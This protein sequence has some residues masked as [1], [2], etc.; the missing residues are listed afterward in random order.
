MDMFW[1]DRSE[2]RARQSVRQ[3]L[4]LLRSELGDALE[5][6]RDRIR[7]RTESLW[8]DVQDLGA[9][10]ERHLVNAADIADPAV[11]ASPARPVEPADPADPAVDLAPEALLLLP[12]ADTESLPAFLHWLDTER[13]TV[14]QRIRNWCREELEDATMRKDRPRMARVAHLW[15]NAGPQD[16]APLEAALEV[17]PLLG[18]PG[19][20]LELWTRWS[21]QYTS[22]LGVPPPESLARTAQNL[23]RRLPG[24]GPGSLALFSPDLVERQVIQLRLRAALDAVRQGEG[25]ILALTGPEGI[26]KSRLMRKFLQELSPAGDDAVLTLSTGPLAPEEE[27]PLGAV[28][29]LLRALA[30]A[31]G[32]GGASE[33]ALA[34]VAELVPEVRGRFPG[35]PRPETPTPTRRGRAVVSVL[36][37]VAEEVPVVIAV[38]DLPDLDK[39]SRQVL[40]EILRAPPPGTLVLV[41]SN[42][43]PARAT[44]GLLGGTARLERIELPPLSVGGVAGLLRSMMTLDPVLVEPLA[45]QLHAASSGIPLL[46]VVMT[47]ALA[48]AHELAPCPDGVWRFGGRDPE[49]MLPHLE[50]LPTTLAPRWNLLSPPLRRVLEALAVLGGPAPTAR[51]SQ[52]AGLS[53]DAFDAALDGLLARRLVREFRSLDGPNH[54][55]FPHEFFRRA[56]YDTISPRRREELHGQAAAAL[57]REAQLRPRLRPLVADHLARSGQSAGAHG[58]PAPWAE[59]GRETGKK[60]RRRRHV[61]AG[62]AAGVLLLLAWWST[63]AEAADDDLVAIFPFETLAGPDLAWMGIGVADLL[64]A[65]LD[66][67][68]GI[69]TVDRHALSAVLPGGQISARDA[70]HLAR[71]LGAGSWVLGQVVGIDDDVVLQASLYRGKGRVERVDAERTSTSAVVGEVDRLARLLLPSLMAGD[72]LPRLDLATRTTGSMGALRSF[73]QGESAFRAGRYEAAIEAYDA[74]TSMDPDFALAHLRTALALEWSGNATASRISTSLAAA[75]ASRSRL[76]AKERRLLGAMIEYYGGL[77]LEAVASLRSLLAE[78]PDFVD[79]WFALAE[80]LFHTLPRTGDP[81]ALEQAHRV[82]L[83]VLTLSPDH[84][85]ALLHLPRTAIHLGDVATAEGAIRRLR[86]TDLADRPIF[87]PSETLVAWAGHDQEAMARLSPLLVNAPPLLVLVSGAFLSVYAQRADLAADLTSILDHPHR[88][89]GARGTGQLWTSV[90]LRR[91]GDVEGSDEALREAA[92]WLPREALRLEALFLLNP[93]PTPA[94]LTSDPP[95]IL[96]AARR[97]DVLS[98]LLSGSGDEGSFPAV[99]AASTDGLS[100]PWPASPA[101]T[102]DAASALDAYLIGLLLAAGGEIAEARRHLEILGA[103]AADPGDGPGGPAGGEAAELAEALGRGLAADLLRREGLPD[104]AMRV[105]RDLRLGGWHQAAFSSPYFAHPRERRL[106]GHLLRE[107]GAVEDAE[108]WMRSLAG[109]TPF[110]GIWPASR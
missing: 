103:I 58:A 8:V 40:A 48:D 31:P 92:R 98:R 106:M 62:L 97:A 101:W 64:A 35:L 20:A 96:E 32:L 29:A 46:L 37:V 51:L 36:E 6:D 16:E 94:D 30:G 4:L 81:E 91:A 42:E 109:A 84:R 3:A 53:P 75:D 72:S 5:A 25:R 57:V 2:A 66:G 108:R 82:L 68:G 110:D 56:A 21:A 61:V 85:E 13:A 70:G 95:S 7:I 107:T 104:E 43:D 99:P 12:G 34:Q 27:S 22:V 45:R 73:V 74:A 60:A 24:K 71:R 10:L 39:E 47:H 9:T 63:G 41:T 65:G 76:P 23:R 77:H 69:R 59:A 26:G 55:D 86:Q 100:L 17:L 50:D 19:E 38:D 88:T 44:S 90:F 28:R 93:D 80:V 1:G 33:D 15:I 79:G 18:R 67:V 52:V 78:E 14:E 49:D 89:E 83:E 102:P 87:L 54:L 11:P 105:L